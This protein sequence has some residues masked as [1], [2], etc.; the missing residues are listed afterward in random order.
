MKY[1][2]KEGSCMDTLKSILMLASFVSSVAIQARQIETPDP[3][4]YGPMHYP[5]TDYSEESGDWCLDWDVW[6]G[7][8]GRTADSAFCPCKSTT[9]HPLPWSAL[10]FGESDFALA[11]IFPGG[12][13]TTFAEVA[14]NPFVSVA[15]L[16]PRYEYSEQSFIAGLT[17]ATR[18]GDGKWRM[19]L[20]TRLP[21]RDIHVM[22]S[23][24]GA[25]GENDLVGDTSQFYMKRN[26]SIEVDG[27]THNNTV[28]AAR[29]DFLTA[30]RISAVSST[31]VPGDPMV[32]YSDPLSL[33]HIT[34]ANVDATGGQPQATAPA[35]LTTNQPPVAVIKRV[36][37]SLPAGALPRWG[38]VNDAITGGVVPSDGSNLA[39]NARGRFASDVNYTPLGGIPA[40]QAT[41]YVVPTINDSGPFIGQKTLGS[42][43]IMNA[44]DVAIAGASDS[45]VDFITT[46]SLDFFEGR[47]KGL[48]DF[49]TE[50]FI[51]RDFCDGRFISEFIF[52]VR[53]PTAKRLCD[54][55]K[56]VLLPRGNNGHYEIRLGTMAG[57]QAYDWLRFKMNLYYSFVLKRTENIA[58]PFLNQAIANIGPCI[59]A[60]VKWGYFEGYFGTTF[61]ASDCCGFHLG[62]DLWVKQRDKLFLCQDTAV[63][64]AGFTH[65]LSVDSDSAIVRNTRRVSHKVRVEFFMT[66]SYC[67][68]TAGWLHT[69]AGK[70]APR[71]TDWYLS[72][73]VSF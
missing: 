35:A 72:M 54:C 61:N 48:G 56:V 12:A 33:G 15:T 29:L 71:D 28:F 17:V 16:S 37:G 55:R 70:N 24:G 67:E 73:Q 6:G 10:L 1:Q 38:D 59:P 21:I 42:T 64:L 49:D 32:K 7:A 13:V 26:E 31:G 43:Q 45:V 34:I 40:N 2:K 9:K 22:E 63:D 50:L 3:L 23:N 11:G 53:W 57:W 30:L 62:Y 36:D 52:G 8:W 39:H 69:F 66:T 47:T 44:I 60:K 4:R 65:P 27:T 41:L 5:T 25:F 18:F 58:A 46:S 19:G 14:D 20:R 68:L 51:G